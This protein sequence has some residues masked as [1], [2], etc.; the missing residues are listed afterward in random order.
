M[1]RS[2]QRTSNG[3]STSAVCEFSRI[4]RWAFR[5][6][7]N[8]RLGAWL[9][10]WLALTG[11]GSAALPGAGTTETGFAP[12]VVLVV[13][14]RTADAILLLTGVVPACSEATYTAAQVRDAIQSAH[15]EDTVSI[16]PDVRDLRAIAVAG[17]QGDARPI[18]V[19]ISLQGV[20]I[21]AS[22]IDRT[23]LPPC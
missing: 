16:P 8:P 20:V 22:R 13:E 23:Q 9:A 19:T 7:R 17:N 6:P 10:L 1:S 3:R 21:S 15:Q 12:D 18:I 4:P 14:N 11:C 5:V 2:C